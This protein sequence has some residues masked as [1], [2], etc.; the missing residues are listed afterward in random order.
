M[1]IKC[2]S[3]TFIP[4][5]RDDVYEFKGIRY[6]TCLDFEEGKEY[7]YPEGEI[8]VKT[9]APYSVQLN[10]SIERFLTGMDYQDVKQVKDPLFLSITLPKDFKDKK[11]LPVLVFIHGGTY[12]GGGCDS[13]SYDR[14]YLAKEND[15]IVIGVNYR[16][17]ILGFSKDKEDNLANLGLLDIIL[18]LKWINKNIKYFNGDK[19]NICLY[20]QSAGADAVR[21]L[22]L[23][24]DC[25]SLYKRV[26]IH[27]DPIKIMDKREKTDLKILEY[28]T[29]NLIGEM[30]IPL[31][32][33]AT[34]FIL[35]EIKVKGLS[36]MMK[37]SPH[38]GINPICKK[39]EIESRLKEVGKTHNILI[40]YNTREV[41]V[42]C[43]NLKLI[44]VLDK[45]ILTRWLIEL[46]IKKISKWLF[47]K[48]A[49]KYK[50]IINS[51]GGN[52]YSFIF[53]YMEKDN[54]F[55]SC[56]SLDFY[57]M[58]N[59]R[60]SPNAKK[61][62]KISDDDKYRL[63]KDYRRLMSEFIKSG[64]FNHFEIEDVIKISK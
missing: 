48:D 60:I 49:I 58:F 47:Y 30:N 17:G 15:L 61:W 35:K 5:D 54:F 46:I 24:K 22:L 19:N 20:G 29:S 25:D 9:D 43:K 11:D 37:F 50:D 63:G 53:S 40:G 10:S 18:A 3:G 1:K 41:S 26:I 31:L 39:E 42:Y 56:H 16:L 36:K 57:L 27:S 13:L 12:K 44:K 2:E 55:G 6:G 14:S 32:K 45:F 8:E 51:N 23:S 33:N 21:L 38:Y 64:K 34:R 28:V 7:I 52:C 62:I 4:L 59:S